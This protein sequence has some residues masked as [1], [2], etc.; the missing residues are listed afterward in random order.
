VFD[1]QVVPIYEKGTVYPAR[2]QKKF[3]LIMDYQ[4]ELEVD[5]VKAKE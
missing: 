5:L 2:K 4:K 1:D 3:H